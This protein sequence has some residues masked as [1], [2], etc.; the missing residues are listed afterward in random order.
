[1]LMY[2]IGYTKSVESLHWFSILRHFQ[3]DGF[4]HFIFAKKEKDC[5]PDGESN[6][7]LPRDRRGSLPLDYRGL[8][9]EGHGELP[10]FYFHSTIRTTLCI[11]SGT[12]KCSWKQ[13]LIPQRLFVSKN[14]FQTKNFLRAGFE[15][16]T[17]GCLLRFQ[18]QST[19]LPTE[20]W[21]VYEQLL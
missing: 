15:P 4:C 8:A 21:K 18:L 12:C 16:A 17:Y 14:I 11:A 10:A 9:D 7:G 1:M 20:L 3:L 5:L 19:A 6:P 2:W 13:I